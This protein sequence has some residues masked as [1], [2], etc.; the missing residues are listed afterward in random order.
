MLNQLILVGRLTHDPETKIL[1]DG[2]KVADI[3]L[4]VQRTFKN[5]EGTYDTD[6]IKVTVWEGLATAI[7][8]YCAKGVL[9]AVKARIQSWKYDLSEDR[10]LNMLEVI[11]ER[12]SYLSSP[13][14]GEFK[15]SEE[16]SE[17]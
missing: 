8:S 1:D 2:R 17:K 5:M 12:I 10:K 6:F 9:V 7:E 3:T 16:S 15:T 14:K 13:S 4:A 11:A